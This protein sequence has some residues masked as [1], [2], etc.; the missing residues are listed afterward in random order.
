MKPLNCREV[1]YE[2]INNDDGKI[3]FKGDEPSIIYTAYRLD[4]EPKSYTDFAKS[5]IYIINPKG[6]GFDGLGHGSISGRGRSH[7]LV[8]GACRSS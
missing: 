3:T 5:K 7:S 8:P 2:K 1:E 6:G 4:K